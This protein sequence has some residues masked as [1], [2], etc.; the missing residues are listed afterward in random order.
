MSVEFYVFK[1]SSTGGIV[2]SK[3]HYDAPT[4]NQVL[5]KVTHSGVCGTD[6]HY[7]HSDIVLGHEG[8]GTVAQVGESVTAFKVGDVVGWG[9]THKTCRACK[10]CLLGES[11]NTECI[12]LLTS[13]FQAKTSIANTGSYTR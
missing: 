11:R 9:Y 12:L 6:E 13:F 10:Q 8:V 5:V 4:G 3:T 7:L 2:E 1:G